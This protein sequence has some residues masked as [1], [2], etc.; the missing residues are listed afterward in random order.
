[1]NESDEC[2]RTVILC[3]VRK[4]YLQECLQELNRRLRRRMITR[5]DVSLDVEDNRGANDWPQISDMNADVIKYSVHFPLIPKVRERLAS[6]V[7]RHV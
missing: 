2:S 6:R 7:L 1:M 4:D 5:G 3:L